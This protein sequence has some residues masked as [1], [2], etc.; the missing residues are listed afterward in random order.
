MYSLE[1]FRI[2]EAYYCE[3]EI[4]QSMLFLYGGCCYEAYSSISRLGK[5]SV[6][7]F[8]TNNGP[9]DYLV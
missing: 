6:N 8:Y 9:T 4:D 1:Q 3:V 2:Y 5:Y 7:P